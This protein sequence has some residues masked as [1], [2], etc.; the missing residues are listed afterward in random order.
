MKRIQSAC[1]EQTIKFDTMSEV[2]PQDEMNVYLKKLDHK[3]T[4]YEILETN[5]LN[6]GAILL[7]I[8]RQY[9]NYSTEGYFS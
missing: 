9:N 1:L 5:N 2:K 6:D 8:K 4:K 3:N 7:K